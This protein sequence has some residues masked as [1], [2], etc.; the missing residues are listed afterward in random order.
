MRHKRDTCFTQRVR[1][2]ILTTRAR[3]KPVSRFGPPDHWSPPWTRFRTFVSQTGPPREPT[4]SLRTKPYRLGQG[5]PPWACPPWTH[6]EHSSYPAGIPLE[7]PPRVRRHKRTQGK[8]NGK[9]Q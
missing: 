3:L 7:P 1:T 8:S 9:R 6:L 4:N 2:F 5:I